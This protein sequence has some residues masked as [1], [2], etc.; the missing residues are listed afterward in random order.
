M[1]INELMKQARSLEHQLFIKYR[2]DEHPTKD[3]I[4]KWYGKTNDYIVSGLDIENAGKLAALDCFKV[5]ESIVRK[6]QVDTIEALLAM[7]KKMVDE[8]DVEQ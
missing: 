2:L 8:D 7:V 6:S 3:E 5:N 1:D 4:S